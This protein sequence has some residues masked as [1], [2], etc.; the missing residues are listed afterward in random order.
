MSCFQAG[1]GVGMLRLEGGPAESLWEELVPERLR[2]LPDDLARMDRLR[3]DEALLSPLEA[4]WGREGE[5]RGRAAKGARSGADPA[6]EVG[7]ADRV[8]APLRPGYEPLLGELSD[9]FHLRRFCLIAIE[10]EV[11]DASTVR[12]LTRPLGAETVAAL[13][14][15]LIAT[16]ERERRFR[17]RA[18][19]CGRAGGRR[20]AGGGRRSRSCS[21]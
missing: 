9:C 20:R 14:R 19:G 18:G 16:A 6:A 11:P 4:R 2:A 3:R 12:R 21:P 15:L 8:E 5:A 10:A 13:S 1:W 7:A 17:A